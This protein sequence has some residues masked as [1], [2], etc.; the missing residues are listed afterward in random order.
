MDSE[1]VRDDRQKEGKKEIVARTHTSQVTEN[2][3]GNS[4]K[5]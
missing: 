3:R 5:R 2:I 1:E 4:R